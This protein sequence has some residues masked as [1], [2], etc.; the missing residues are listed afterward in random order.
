MANNAPPRF[1]RTAAP[2]RQ[3]AIGA[4]IQEGLGRADRI[5]PE[6]VRALL[7]RLDAQRRRPE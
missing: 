1:V 3:A 5:L 7:G 4:A 6:F 2:N